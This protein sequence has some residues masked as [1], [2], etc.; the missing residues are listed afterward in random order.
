MHVENQ[1]VL[2]II[3]KQTNKETQLPA[4]VAVAQKSIVVVD[5][6]IYPVHLARRK[7]AKVLS[8]K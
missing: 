3:E 6:L 2:T 1:H 8:R 7:P 4:P 5:E